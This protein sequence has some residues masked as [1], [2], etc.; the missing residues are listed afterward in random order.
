MEE[1]VED[2]TRYLSRNP[3]IQRNFYLQCSLCILFLCLNWIFKTIKQFSSDW[4]KTNEFTQVLPTQV[5]IIPVTNISAVPKMRK[6]LAVWGF[7]WGVDIFFSRSSCNTTGSFLHLESGLVY[8]Y[9]T[10]P[11]TIFPEMGNN[12]KNEEMEDCLPLSILSNQTKSLED[13]IEQNVQ[14]HLFELLKFVLRT[15][16]LPSPGW[17]TDAQV[18]PHKRPCLLPPAYRSRV[19]SLWL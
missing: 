6:S 18:L 16:H 9:S 14:M 17:V 13:K 8:R 15:L 11:H 3:W 4:I 2:W 7:R 19:S 10:K 5:K 12:R 1:G